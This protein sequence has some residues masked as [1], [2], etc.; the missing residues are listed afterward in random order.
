M[1]QQVYFDEAGFTGNH[2]LDNNQPTFVCASIALDSDDAEYLVSDVTRR[3]GLKGNELKGQS[4]VRYGRGQQ[5]VCWLL[6]Q[7]Q[8]LAC[9]SVADKKF[10]LAAKFY[11]YIF[12]PLLAPISSVF[13][14]AGFHAFIANLLY[15]LFQSRDEHTQHIMV[16]FEKLMRTGESSA[17]DTLLAPLDRGLVPSLPAGQILTFALCHRQQIVD[18]I[19][20]L[21]TMGGMRNWMLELTTTSLFWLLS[22][23]GQRYDSLEVYCDRSKPIEISRQVFDAMIGRE[24]RIY[25]K[26]GGRA[27]VALTY[28]LS[29]PLVLVDSATS[30]GIQ[31]ADVVASSVAFALNNPNGEVSR[32]ILSIAD[33]MFDGLCIVPD[34]DAV[35]LRMPGPLVNGLILNELVERTL[36]GESLLDGWRR[37]ISSAT[38]ASRQLAEG[39]SSE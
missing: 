32:E 16:E 11:E 5:A 10:A 37:F 18:E 39:S 26:L 21:A 31:V 24:D 29:R 23:L 22:F 15:L 25:M 8:G 19:D 33:G 34:L 13:Y 30:P 7:C 1:A 12:E 4:L 14:A 28:N 9:I 35:D 3:F 27:E 17:V 38:L 2:M 20:A 6:E 36:R